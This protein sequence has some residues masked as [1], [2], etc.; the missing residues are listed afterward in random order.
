MASLQTIESSTCGD[1]SEG[2]AVNFSQLNLID[3]AGSES[4]RAETTGVRR[5]EGSYINK[6]LLTLGT[7]I[8]KLTDGKATHIPYRDSKLTRLLQSSLSGQG[9]VSLIC[10][11]TPSSSNAEETHNTL[12]FAHRAKCVEIQAS[13]NKII[14][15]KSLIK[16]YQNEIRCLKQEL[17]QLKRGIVTVTPQKDTGEDDIFL[18]KQ[19][20]EDGHVKLQ[21]RLEQEE[22]AKAALLGRIQRLTKLILVSTKTNQSPIFPPHAAPRRR[23]SFG[24][25]ELA[26][27][28]YRRRD[29]ILDNENGVFYAPLEGFGETNDDGLKEEKKNKKHGLLNWFKL[30]KRDSGLTTLTS[31]DGDKSS[32]TKSYTTPSTPQAESVNFP[33]EPGISNSIIPESIPADDLPDV[34]HDRELPADD[35]SFQETPLISIKT[36]DHVELLREQLKILTGEVALHSSVLKRLSDEAAKNPKNEQIQMEMSKA[37]EGIKAK[38]QQIASLEKQMANSISVTQNRMSKLGLSPSYAELL[39]ELNEKSLELEVKT[40]DNNIIQDQLQ[41][42]ICECEEL[43]ETIASLKQQLVQAHEMKDFSSVSV[44]SQYFCEQTNFMESAPSIDVSAEFLHQA[45]LV[46]EVQELKQKVSE[47][48]DTKSQLEAR[49]QKLAEESAYA[50][51]L[52]SAA[53]VELKALSEEVTKLMNHNERLAAELA[54]M[55]NSGQRR[56]SNG[57]KNT[58]RDSHVKR[59]E[60][61]IKRELTVSRERELEAALKEKEK[62]EAELHKKVEESKQRETFLENELANMWV[63]MAKL[64]NAQGNEPGD[65]ESM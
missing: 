16:K 4:S 6:S 14:D 5:R 26:Y 32:V 10:T 36:I 64:K 3:L 21:S 55:R 1:C 27:L 35:L 40:A 13:Q 53:G 62:R 56:V 52:A 19:K 38:N 61:I 2:G 22:E 7:V 46:S 43:Q 42:K 49:N 17:E 18:L 33:S 23:H 34:V 15:E 44:K 37:S 8:A 29:M 41:Q 59:H 51:G 45:H 60:P 24:E 9:R 12:K 63:L 25:E 28:P 54:S 57:P 65:L 58:K 39:E 11:V 47:L 48:S 31:S 30:R 20:L 50:K